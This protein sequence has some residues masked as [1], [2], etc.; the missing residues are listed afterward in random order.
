[1]K[2]SCKAFRVKSIKVSTVEFLSFS[3]CE[4]VLRQCPWERPDQEGITETGH[5]SEQLCRNQ[6]L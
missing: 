6:G 5:Q 2:G 3:D 4:D 1:M